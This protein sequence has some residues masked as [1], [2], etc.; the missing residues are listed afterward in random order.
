MH[1]HHTVQRQQVIH[2]SEDGFLDLTCVA[3]FPMMHSCWSKLITMTVLVRG[4]VHL[5]EGFEDGHGDDGEFRHMP[6]VFF[7]L[8][9]AR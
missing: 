3:V 1:G 8:S 2:D 4:A 6:A 7:V 5:R 9:V